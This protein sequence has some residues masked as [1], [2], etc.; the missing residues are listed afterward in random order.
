MRYSTE[1]K[2]RKY[3]KGN[4]VLSFAR[5]FCDEYGK[6]LMDATTK[7]GIDAAKTA[8]KKAVQKTAEATGDLI[9]NKIDDKKLAFKNNALFVSCIS[10]F[11]NILIDNAEDSDIVMPMYN[12]IECSKK[13]SKTTGSLW[14]YYGNQANSGLGGAVNNISYSIKD[15]KS[16]DSKTIITGKLEDNNTEQEVEIVVPLKHFSNFWRTLDMSLINCEINFTLAWFENCVITNSMQ[17][18]MFGTGT[19][20][21]PQFPEID[22]PA[23]ATFKIIDTKQ[24]VPVVTLSTEN[25]KFLEQ[26]K[27]GFKRT[28]KLNKYRSEMTNQAQNNNLNYLTDPIFTKVS[29]LFV[30]SFENENDRRSF[31]K[32]Y[33]PNVQI[34]NFNVLINGKIFLTFQKKMTKKHLNKLLKWEEIMIT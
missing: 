26:L 31:S 8:S 28:L 19:D 17:R 30:L 15:S 9:G 13:Y 22:N 21:N 12:L 24:Y 2:F 29:R 16:F 11:N 4:G 18:K 1:R 23:G 14:N 6:K 10:K 5:E 34:K 32:Y 20:Q 3:I 25:N 33:V 27:T 7:I